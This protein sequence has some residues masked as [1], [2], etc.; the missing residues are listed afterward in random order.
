MRY[1]RCEGR[2]P[3]RWSNLVQIGHRKIAYA[4]ALATYFTHYSVTERYETI[5]GRKKQHNLELV[6]GHDTPMSNSMYYLLLTLQ[7]RVAT[8]IITYD[9]QIAV[10][11]VWRSA[12]LGLRIPD[13]S[14]L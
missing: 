7:V 10:M 8:A 5:L 9:H 11:L 2:E 14:Q 6:A 12:R 3:K 13:Q 4:N 1:G